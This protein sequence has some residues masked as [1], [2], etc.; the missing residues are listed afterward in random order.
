MCFQFGNRGEWA[1][2]SPGKECS[3]SISVLSV[4]SQSVYS[5]STLVLPLSAIFREMHEEIFLEV[6]NKKP[7]INQTKTEPQKTKPENPPSNS[8][9]L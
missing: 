1:F 6:V 5:S 7:K 3:C 9:L 4:F 2:R 8:L